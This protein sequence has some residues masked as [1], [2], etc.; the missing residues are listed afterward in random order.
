MGT[1]QYLWSATGVAGS[2]LVQPA[3]VKRPRNSR[4][5][6][7]KSLAAWLKTGH[8]GLQ[9]RLNAAGQALLLRASS[10]ALWS[11]CGLTW[12]GFPPARQYVHLGL[13][14]DSDRAESLLRHD[15]SFSGTDGIKRCGVSGSRRTR[16]AM[17]R[18]GKVRSD[19]PRNPLRR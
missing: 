14:E 12:F 10:R 6:A 18:S 15:S 7:G 16:L 1:P 9:R 8:R 5:P 19:A 3:A 13:G 11:C 17:S 2:L 4:Q